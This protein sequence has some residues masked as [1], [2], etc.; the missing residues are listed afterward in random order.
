MTRRVGAVR[1]GLFCALSWCASALAQDYTHVAPKEPAPAQPAPVIAPPSPPQHSLS[2]KPDTRLLPALKGLELVDDGKKIERTGVSVYG[3]KVDPNLSVLDDT[4]IRN[5]LAQFL[6]KPLQA[7]DLDAISKVVVAWCRAHN[8]PLVAVAFPEQDISTGTVQIVVTLYRVGLITVTGNRWFSDGAITDEMEL[9]PGDPFDFG[10][11]TDDLNRLG[12]NPFRSVNAV[13]ERSTIPGATDLALHVQDRFPV[14]VYASYDDEGVPATGRDRYSVGFNW[15]NV[16]G[17]D[18]Q[19]SYQFMTSADLWHKRD[20]GVGHSNDPRLGAHSATYQVP[21]PWGGDSLTLFGTFEQQVP[22]VG[23]DF[24]QVGHSLQMS[25]RYD[26]ALPTIRQFSQSLH[27]GFDYKRTDNNLAFGGSQ[28]YDTAT[29]VEQ[30]LLIYDAVRRDSY[31]QTAIENQFVYSPGGFSAGNTT[32]IYVASGVTGARANYEYDNLQITRLTALPWQMSAFLRIDGQIA[33]T[34]LLPSEQLGA[35]GN[36]SVRGYD[37]R[38]ASGTQGVL[39]SFELRS[40][41]YNPL[42]H[43]WSKLADSGQLLI[44]YD[45]GFVSDIHAQ[46]KQAKSASLQSTGFG[47]RYGIGRYLDVRFDYGWQL[48]R[49]PGAAHPG[50]LADVSVTL[51]Y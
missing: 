15:G 10:V 32:A 38:A 11:L 46:T 41:P 2:V 20:R 35:G 14:R 16:F 28:I 9:S 1:L 5:R 3:V 31:G 22:N 37:P 13:L 24:D 30:F 26:K 45:S 25:V 44:F 27:I 17:L 39:A 7:R 49:A 18:Q 51:A 8:F 48:T 36:D 4:R 34:E 33:S 23:T 6:G 12:A 42:Q 21:L 43:L 19:F 40:P 29:N 50:N 47:A